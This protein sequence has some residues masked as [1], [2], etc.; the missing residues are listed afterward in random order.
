MFM[1][2]KSKLDTGGYSEGA[3]LMKRS[4]DAGEPAAQY[5]L[6][7]LHE[8]GLGVPRDLS[9]A[10]KWTEQAANGGNIRA[11]HDLAVFYAQGDGGPQSYA[12]AVNWFR[13]AAEFG[14]VDSQYNLGVLTSAASVSILIPQKPYF[15]LSSLPAAETARL[16]RGSSSCQKPF[17]STRSTLRPAAPRTGDQN[18]RPDRQMASSQQAMGCH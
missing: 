8:K 4:A 3:A 1:L 12:A 15:G 13:K 16:L 7:K 10:R 2:G 11:M 5:R 18:R 14:V 9:L 17:P 6:G